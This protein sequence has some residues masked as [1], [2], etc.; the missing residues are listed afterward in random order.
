MLKSVSATLWTFTSLNEFVYWAWKEMFLCDASAVQISAFF[1]LKISPL[2]LEEFEWRW[3]RTGHWLAQC[4]DLV[5]GKSLCKALEGEES[6]FLK[7]LA[8]LKSRNF[9]FYFPF[10]KNGI[11]HCY[12]MLTSFKS[13]NNWMDSTEIDRWGEANII[14]R[15]SNLDLNLWTV[16]L[17][18]SFSGSAPH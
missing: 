1:G 14:W 2:R 18:S 13:R 12:F 9:V 16:R 6:L 7:S 11:I 3:Y 15:L 5:A 4:S 10:D 17:Y 8:P